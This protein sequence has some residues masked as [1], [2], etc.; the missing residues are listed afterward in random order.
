MERLA[1]EKAR[2]NMFKRIFNRTMDTLFTPTEREELAEAYME[3]SYPYIINDIW[4]TKAHNLIDYIDD[5]TDIIRYYELAHIRPG[6]DVALENIRVHI[7]HIIRTLISLTDGDI[8][9]YVPHFY[10]RRYIL[11]ILS[12]ERYDEILDELERLNRLVYETLDNLTDRYKQLMNPA[13]ATLQELA[14]DALSPTQ[15]RYAINRGLASIKPRRKRRNT[16]GG[17]RLKLTR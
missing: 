6:D 13:K 11:D 8:R 10:K 3:T 7:E 14:Y 12:V 16:M 15:R 17:R 5:I 9:Q 1:Y 4:K 2:L